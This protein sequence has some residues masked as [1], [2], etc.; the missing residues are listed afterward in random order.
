M[1][2]L[3]MEVTVHEHHQFQASCCKPRRIS[4][5]DLEPNEQIDLKNVVDIKLSKQIQQVHSSTIID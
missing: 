2:V 5:H 3:S 1:S 4:L